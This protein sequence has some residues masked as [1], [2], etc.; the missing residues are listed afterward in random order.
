[1]YRILEKFVA[2]QML[3][4]WKNMATNTVL[5]LSRISYR[6]LNHLGWFGSSYM[7]HKLIY[8]YVGHGYHFLLIFCFI[9]IILYPLG[10][11]YFYH[12][13]SF[14]PN[15]RQ[16][17]QIL[18]TLI[19]YRFSSPVYRFSTFQTVGPSRHLTSKASKASSTCEP[20]WRRWKTACR[21]PESPKKN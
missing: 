18:Q 20:V 13:Q 21:S 2:H 19:F 12:V 15:K 8:I 16:I 5:L 10:K 11:I 1:M 17:L 4:I 3:Y 6:Y 9:Y 14:P 7:I